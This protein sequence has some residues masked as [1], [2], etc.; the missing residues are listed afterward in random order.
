[1]LHALHKRLASWDARWAVPGITPRKVAVPSACMGHLRSALA[2]AD[3][4]ELRFCVR[5]LYNRA[6]EGRDLAMV[7]ASF[8]L[9]EVM[10]PYGSTPGGDL[11]QALQRV[12][13]LLDGALT[14][15]RAIEP[16]PHDGR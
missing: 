8:D 16:A 13:T 7:R 1:M 15:D 12:A 10:G 3:V 9:L 4:D 5:A 14:P 11:A 6:S 2:R